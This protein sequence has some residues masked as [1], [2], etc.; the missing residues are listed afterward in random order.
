MGMDKVRVISLF[1]LAF[2]GLR[3]YLSVRRERNKPRYRAAE[4]FF[5]AFLDEIHDLNEGRRD[6]AEVLRQAFP[7]HEQAYTRFRLHLNGKGLRKLDDA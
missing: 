5:E 6:P 1:G 3:I 7:K 2:I 4:R